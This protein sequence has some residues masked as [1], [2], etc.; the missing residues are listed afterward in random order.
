MKKARFV[1]A[2]KP[3]TP[4][5]ATLKPAHKEDAG[6]PTLSLSTYKPGTLTATGW[7]PRITAS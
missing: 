4:K 5:K 2:W 3:G 6:L 7:T 1:P